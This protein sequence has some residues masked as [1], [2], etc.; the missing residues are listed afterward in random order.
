MKGQIA[1]EQCLAGFQCPTKGL[2]TPI[3][4]PE[5]YYCPKGVH[6]SPK[7]PAGK[8]NSFKYAKSVADC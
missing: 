2:E 6:P 1:C 4:C 8:Y 5:G 7:C 3:P